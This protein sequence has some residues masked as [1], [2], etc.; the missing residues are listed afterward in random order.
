M[1]MFKA[2]ALGVALTMSASI[3]HANEKDYVLNT[4]STGGTYHPV[5]TAISTLTKVKLLPKE[6]FSLT[7][8]NS[9]GSGANVQAL[10]AGTADF[11]ILQGLFGAYAKTG[12]GPISEPQKNIRSIS[13]LWQNVEHFVVPTELA[14]TGTMDDIVALKGQ[15]AGM[16]GQSSGTIGSNRVL[17][18]GLGLDMDRDFNLMYAGYGPTGAALANGQITSAGIPGGTP[19]GAITQLMAANEGKFTIL[20]VTPEQATKM[21]GDRK[22][23]VP[24]TIPAGTYPGQTKD[25]QTVAQPNFLAVND[26]VDE[27]HVYM[28]TK[29]MFENL[30]FL[31]AIH[32]AT[33]AMALDKALAGLP[34][35]L[36]PGAQRYYEEAG[37]TIPDHLKAQ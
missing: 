20:D 4:A 11:A 35:P 22:L 5:G 29:T 13:M 32:P 28:L 2:L 25:I 12:T 30:P 31:Q 6:K 10:G 21:D 3:A 8:V 15:A 14:K 9:A 24:Y 19:V 17:L 26:T 16:G 23:W 7:A 33:K 34:V 18:A 36:H 1:K 37:L 27:N